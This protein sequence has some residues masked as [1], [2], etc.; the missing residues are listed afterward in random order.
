MNVSKTAKTVKIKVTQA[1]EFIW[2]GLFNSELRINV[3]PG[4]SRDVRA[5]MLEKYRILG[6]TQ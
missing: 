5:E 3:A 2:R 4:E 6:R 1:A